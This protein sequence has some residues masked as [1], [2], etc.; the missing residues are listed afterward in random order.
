MKVLYVYVLI[1]KPHFGSMGF[2]EDS[3]CGK[4][5]KSWAGWEI[6]STGS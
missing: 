2:S 4:A 3:Y 6:E 5:M 1:R